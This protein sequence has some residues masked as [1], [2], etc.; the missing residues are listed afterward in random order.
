[1]KALLIIAIA[2]SSAAATPEKGEK[3]LLKI[4]AAERCAHYFGIGKS[5]WECRNSMSRMFKAMDMHFTKDAKG[6]QVAIAFRKKFFEILIDPKT[7]QYL[8]NLQEKLSSEDPI[9]LWEFTV[10]SFDGDKN[11]ALETIAVL[12]QDNGFGLNLDY[13][14]S[15]YK[16][17]TEGIVALLR[18]I[19]A[20]T[21]SH[22]NFFP[23]P[24]GINLTQ[25]DLYH[26]YN[27]AYLTHVLDKKGKP[28]LA[29]F[30]TFMFNTLYEFIVEFCM[31]GHSPVSPLALEF[32]V[33]KMKGKWPEC[34][35]VKAMDPVKNA[36]TWGDLYL[37]YVGPIWSRNMEEQ[38][39]NYDQFVTNFSAQP[40]NFIKDVFRIGR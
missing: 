15:K 9:Y 28:K 32:S 11:K 34:V 19:Y 20:K 6:S 26:F 4:V 36:I 21:L 2:L 39:P 27:L 24:S 10:A 35:N 16:K 33:Q 14:E 38:I 37:G 18:D 12:L 7:Q 8:I 29:T 1:M 30:S 3:I 17:R 31:K 23:Y 25:R 13:L 5:F 40:E 22:P